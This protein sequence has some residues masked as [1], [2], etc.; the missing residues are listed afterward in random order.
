MHTSFEFKSSSFAITKDGSPAD[1][2]VILDWD[3]RDRLGVLMDRPVGALG[4]GLLIF[5]AITAFYDCPQRK[6]RRT[7][8]Y[9]DIFLFHVGGRWGLF[10]MFD[11]WP[12]H[13]EVFVP[14]DPREVLRAVNN[15][16]ITHLILPERQRRA[17]AH[18]FKEPQAAADRLKKCFAYS[19]SGLV[20]G[21]DIVIETEAASIFKNYAAVLDMEAY[22]ADPDPQDNSKNPNRLLAVSSAEERTIAAQ[23][24]ATRLGEVKKHDPSWMMATGRLAAAQKSGRLVESFR[25][26]DVEEALEMLP[27]SAQAPD[28]AQSAES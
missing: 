10:S 27:E 9:P 20:P 24:V 11:F 1:R 16:G 7:P 23:Y 26:V 17:T 21:G 13:K 14:A 12:D 22:L 4:A 18:R 2:D 5:L 15:R 25:E 8:I 3:V 28:S 6:R 19:P